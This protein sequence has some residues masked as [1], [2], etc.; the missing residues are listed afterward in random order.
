MLTR[1]KVAI[2]GVAVA[3]AALAGTGIAVASGGDAE[4]DHAM[5]GAQLERASQVALTE[6]GGG[7]VTDSEVGDEESRYEIEVTKD[8]GTQVDVQLDADFHVVDSSVDK[9]EGNEGNDAGESDAPESN[10]A[11]TGR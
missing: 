5:T 6:T 2:A 9:P 8:D 1:T 4:P 3:A 10:D 7:R 11:Q